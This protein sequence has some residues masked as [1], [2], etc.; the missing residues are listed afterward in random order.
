MIHPKMEGTGG[1]GYD[2]IFFSPELGKTLAQ[3]TLDEKCE[4][5]HR[6]RAI[7]KLI[8]VIKTLTGN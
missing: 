4:V 6:G 5:S 2:P 8:P 7:R 3:A 1:F